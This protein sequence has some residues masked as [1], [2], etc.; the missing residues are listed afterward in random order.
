MIYNVIMFTNKNLKPSP[1]KGLSKEEKDYLKKQ[2][3]KAFIDYRDNYIDK[4]A[5]GTYAP[6]AIDW[7]FYKYRVPFL[8]RISTLAQDMIHL[9]GIDDGETIIRCSAF[10]D[11]VDIIEKK[12][13]P[14]DMILTE[15]DREEVRVFLEYIISLLKKM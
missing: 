9:V 6:K 15:K 10:K 1:E 13:L 7:E 8:L 11:F 4:I 14:P 12:K 2:Y 3:L 5:D